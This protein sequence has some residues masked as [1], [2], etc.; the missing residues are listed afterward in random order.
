[1]SEKDVFVYVGVYDAE[2]GAEFDYDVL[3]D[4]H[5]GGAVGSYDAAV[6]SKDEAGK[7]HIRKHEKP[8]QHGAWSGLAI[9]ALVGVVFPP[10]VLAT[11]AVGAVAGGLTGHFARGMSRGDV[12]EFADTLDEGE[13]ALVVVGASKLDETI[14]SEL[15][16]ADRAYEKQLTADAHELRKELDQAIDQAA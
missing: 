12:K 4:L 8:T 3:R 10:S 7:V 5:A 2:D 9:G 16:R 1:M 6:V 11:G 15:K 14:R 13:A